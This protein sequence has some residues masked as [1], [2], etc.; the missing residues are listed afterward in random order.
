VLVLAVLVHML[1][2]AQMGQELPLL[3]PDGLAQLIGQRA[4]RGIHAQPVHPW[5]K[6]DTTLMQ[7]RQEL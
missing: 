6:R 3:H 5:D 7:C 2:Y 1:K 4:F